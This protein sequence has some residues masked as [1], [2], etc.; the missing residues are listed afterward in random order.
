MERD[1]YTRSNIYSPV[2]PREFNNPLMVRGFADLLALG[3]IWVVLILIGQV[4]MGLYMAELVG[5]YLGLPALAA[6]SALVM[7]YLTVDVVTYLCLRG[8][9]IFQWMVPALCLA[10]AAAVPG[11]LVYLVEAIHRI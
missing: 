11:L 9:M 2:N 8:R 5:K 10:A 6:G 1:T 3:G 4:V 7:A